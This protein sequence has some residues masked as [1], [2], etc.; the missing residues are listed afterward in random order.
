M[1]LLRNIQT[2]GCLSN[3]AAGVVVDVIPTL[4]RGGRDVQMSAGDVF[5]FCVQER[6]PIYS[7]NNNHTFNSGDDKKKKVLRHY[8]FPPERAP[9]LKLTQ[10]IF[11]TKKKKKKKTCRKG[12]SR[13]LGLVN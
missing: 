10:R 7:W 2:V 4:Y 9:I 13:L 12:T 3:A 11:N 1:K 8:C 6:T 5:P